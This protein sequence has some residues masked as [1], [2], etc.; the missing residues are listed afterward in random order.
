MDAQTAQKGAVGQT[1]KKISRGRRGYALLAAAAAIVLA[2]AF[3]LP[4]F[5]IYGSS[6][7][8]TLEKG[9][10][11]AA[12]KGQNWEQGDIIVFWHHNKILIKR[13][14]AEPGSQ[15]DIGADGIVYVD[16]TP[17]PEA[18]LTD[19]SAGTCSVELPCTV[20]DGQYFVLGDARDIS[21]DSRSEQIGCV[22]KEQVIGK[23][24]F[25]L[26]GSGGIGPVR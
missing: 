22:S 5:R 23:V 12:V 14:I 1:D 25:R 9:E 26:W 21:A 4:V 10:L 24:A 15:V 3:Y 2:G 13:L 16:K 11:V 6:M 18:Y 19:R 7:S 17:L 20:P 8:P